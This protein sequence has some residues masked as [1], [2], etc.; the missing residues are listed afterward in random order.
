[1]RDVFAIIADWLERDVPFALGTLVQ[2]FD[3]SPAP[4][5]TTIAVDRDSRIVGN[6]GAGCY[7]GDIV[8]ACLQT[9]SDAQFRLLPINL[10]STDEITGSAGCGGAIK[11]AIWKPQAG[12]YED[13]TAIAR[14]LRDVRVTLPEG[15]S[16]TV[17]AKQRLVLVGATTLAQELA[18]MA[19]SLDFFVTVADPRPLFATPERVP[20]AD[21]I[22]LEWPDEYLP[23]VLSDIAALVVISHD[24]KFDIAALASA[25]RSDVPY[26][27]LLG[28]RRSQAARRDALREA[29]FG[30]PALSRIHGPVGLDLGG[31]STAETALSILAQIVAQ[32]NSR[33]GA[34]LEALTSPIHDPSTV[35]A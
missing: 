2:T 30:E 10:S 3:S 25:L 17:R 7:E 6:I 22:V 8:Q 27:G 12:F 14:G 29:G 21:E 5:G 28:S 35:T 1:M 23:P 24:P 13:A 11:I 31:R 19:R 18:H 32:R 4:I 34:P 16:F 33:T 20:D 9:V 15:F 26:I